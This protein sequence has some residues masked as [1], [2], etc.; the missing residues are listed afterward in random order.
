MEKKYILK[1]PKVII[2]IGNCDQ[3]Q[4]SESFAHRDLVEMSYVLK[5]T[6]ANT[7]LNWMKFGFEICYCGCSED[8]SVLGHVAKTDLYMLTCPDVLGKT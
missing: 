3:T 2:V 7:F 6:V 8:I 5:I 1:M 4:L